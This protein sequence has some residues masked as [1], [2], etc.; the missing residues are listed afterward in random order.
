MNLTPLGIEDKP[1]RANIMVEPGKVFAEI[2]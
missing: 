2:S 1:D